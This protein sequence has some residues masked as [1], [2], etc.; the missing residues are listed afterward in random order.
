MPFSPDNVFDLL[1]DLPEPL[2]VTSVEGEIALV[3][4]AL[5]ALSGFDDS[6][7]VGEPVTRLMPQSERRRV[8]VVRWLTRWADDPNPEQLR[9]LTLELITKNGDSL[10]ISVRVSRYESLG[11]SWFLVVLRDVTSEHQ[12]LSQLRHAQLPDDQQREFGIHGRHRGYRGAGFPA[13]R[14]LPVHR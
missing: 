4:R 5:T 10:Q 9:Y 6:D 12:T 11:S 8:D 3:N 14:K 13:R 1:N 2:M 7:L